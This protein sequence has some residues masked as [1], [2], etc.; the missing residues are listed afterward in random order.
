MS[1]AIQLDRVAA[2]RTLFVETFAGTLPLL[3]NWED[4]PSAFR[5]DL[6]D[7]AERVAMAALHIGPNPTPE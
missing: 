2:G 4:Q 7:K 3:P 5:D 1:Q 6:C